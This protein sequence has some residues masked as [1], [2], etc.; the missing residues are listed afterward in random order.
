MTAF[1][2]LIFFLGAVYAIWVRGWLG[3]KSEGMTDKELFG[4]MICG[5]GVSVMYVGLVIK[6]W[7]VM[8]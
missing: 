3:E 1:G 4:W 6:I 8:P 7:E 2:S 5:A